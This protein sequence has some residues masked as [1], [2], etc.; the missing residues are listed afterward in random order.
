M[1]VLGVDHTKVE[2]LTFEVPMERRWR[3][4][5]WNFRAGFLG[6]KDFWD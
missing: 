5:E 2:S 1:E 3:F 4:P 6:V